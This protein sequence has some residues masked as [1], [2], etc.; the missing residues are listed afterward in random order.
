M[1]TDVSQ[2]IRER[3]LDTVRI[4]TEDDGT[5]LGLPYP[6]TVPCAKGGFE[7][8]Y[9]WDIYFACRGLALQGLH[10]QV[11]WNCDNLLHLLD[12]FDFVPNASCSYLVKCS[13]PPYLGETVALVLAQSPDATWRRRAAEALEREHAFWMERRRLACGLNHYGHHLGDM[14]G[15]A[16]V[17]ERLEQE[18]QWLCRERMGMQAVPDPEERRRLADHVLAEAESGW[19]FTPRFFRRCGGIAA[20]DLNCLL[21][22]TEQILA[23]LW[24]DLDEPARA[25]Q[26]RQTADERARLIRRLCWDEQQGC[27]ADWDPGAGKCLTLVT[28]ATFQPLWAGLATSDQARRTLAV[29]ER[30]LILPHGVATCAVN[31]SGLRYQWDYPNAWP[32]LQL[33]AWEACD[34]YGHEAL[35]R[36]IAAAFA[37]TVESNF[38]A[39]GELWEKYNACAGTI[40]VQDEY[41]MPA[42]MGW[43]AGVYLAARHRLDGGA[44]Q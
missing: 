34:R 17:P 9:Y 19:D 32:P 16:A 3:W 7:H 24:D 12:R 13:Q 40:E 22:R 5:H 42:M 27:F 6:Y 10:K 41:E 25:D 36:R 4:H 26:W 15:D 33:I 31:Q 29:A 30:E 35:A 2:F 18:F 39:T 8:L 20:V 28:A 1:Q 21:Y 14:I 44:D 38:A 43:T 11:R 23:G 37:A